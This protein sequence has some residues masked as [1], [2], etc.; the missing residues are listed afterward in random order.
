MAWL[1]A[2]GTPR[3]IATSPWPPSKLARRCAVIWACW[4]KLAPMLVIGR[5]AGGSESNTVMGMP[6]R[7]ACSSRGLS[8][9]ASSRSIV[10][11]V[12]FERMAA[13]SMAACSSASALAGGR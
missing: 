12:G 8:L 11:P 5:S 7:S 10:I 6:S 2:V 1:G 4:Q 9:V 3:M 13:W